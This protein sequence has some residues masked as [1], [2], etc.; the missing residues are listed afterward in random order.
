MRS[1]RS[2][3]SG[4]ASASLSFPLGLP[5]SMGLWSGPRG[6]TPRSS[7]RSSELPWTLPELNARLREWEH[8]YN[9]LRPHQALGYLTP[10]EALE[11]F[12]ELAPSSHMS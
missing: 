10:A 11:K 9:H 12:W 5:S 7:T 1:L 3:A 8:I 6:P 2:S 4:G